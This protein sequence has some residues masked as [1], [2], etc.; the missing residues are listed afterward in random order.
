MKL[1]VLAEGVDEQMEKE[2]C[3][4]RN[5]ELEEEVEENEEKERVGRERSKK[6][7]LS[8]VKF[9]LRMIETS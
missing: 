3:W 7:H 4:G 2:W 6:D 9:C 1:G 5:L 8:N